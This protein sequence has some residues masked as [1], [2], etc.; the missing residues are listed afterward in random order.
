MSS[1][2]V[3][4]LFDA[5]GASCTG[6][7]STVIVYDEAEYSVPSWTWNVKLS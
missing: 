7:T 1:F 4:V 3:T 6:S 2:V 5:V